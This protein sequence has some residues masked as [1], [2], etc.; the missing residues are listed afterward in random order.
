MVGMPA[1]EVTVEEVGE[2]VEG[3]AEVMEE[4]EVV[5]V[6]AEGP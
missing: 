3:E 5:V 6:D 2:M 4:E 1:V